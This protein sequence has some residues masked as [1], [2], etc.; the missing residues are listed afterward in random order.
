MLN[1]ELTIF[2]LRYIT[3]ITNSYTWIVHFYQRLHNKPITEGNMDDELSL[4]KLKLYIL[5]STDA[6]QQQCKQQ[7]PVE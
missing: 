3:T 5:S 4:L 6:E 2:T 1:L 7:L